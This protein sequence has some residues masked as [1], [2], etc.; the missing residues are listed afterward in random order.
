[1]GY[2]T[3]NGSVYTAGN[4]ILCRN[5]IKNNPNLKQ[6]IY[7][8][9]PNVIGH[10]FERRRT[11]NNFVKPF[12]EISTFEHFDKSTID[13]INQK[14]IN[15][16]YIL[17]LFKNLSLNEYDYSDGVIKNQFLL[18]PFSLLYLKK[19]SVICK[20]NG[21][22]L[23]I[24]SPPIPKSK[25]NVVKKY[26]NKFLSEIGK[27]NLNTEFKY[28]FETMKN[29]SDSEFLDGLH[30][31][32]EYLLKNRIFER[33]RIMMIAKKHYEESKLCWEIEF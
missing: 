12:Y 31:K 14:F 20:N 15:Y 17:K 3:S 22:I 23:T 6:V 26:E 24:L 10:K 2:L 27:N 13:K 16:F 9:V 8:S 1:M 18:S 29:L 4:F 25:L 33:N 30:M 28:Y 32:R 5:V 19:M 11:S 21:V 7:L